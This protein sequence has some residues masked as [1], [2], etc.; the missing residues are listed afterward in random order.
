MYFEGTLVLIL[1]LILSQL[2]IFLLLAIG[3]P[4]SLEL[5]LFI[6]FAIMFIF[7]I[8]AVIRMWWTHTAWKR[9][10]K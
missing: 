7:Q 10:H 4:V 6:T 9:E 2:S 3:Y 8:L 5:W 1:G